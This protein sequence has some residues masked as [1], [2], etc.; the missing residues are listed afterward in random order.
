MAMRVPRT[1]VAD[2]VPGEGIAT[3][4]HHVGPQ[5]IQR[6]Q[7]LIGQGPVRQVPSCVGAKSVA[8]EQRC[9]RNELA[10]MIGIGHP[11][12]HQQRD[13][14]FGAVGLA[15]VD[16]GR[17][18]IGVSWSSQIVGCPKFAIRSRIRRIVDGGARDGRDKQAAR[19]AQIVP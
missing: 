15:L 18:M 9:T 8:I 1:V 19:P 13:L 2:I 5:L 4:C 17:G 3:G 7:S 6:R 16:V 14:L 11:L 10:R 12:A